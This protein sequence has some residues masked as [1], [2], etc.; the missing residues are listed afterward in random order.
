[1]RNAGGVTTRGIKDFVSA[2]GE[3]IFGVVEDDSGVFLCWEGEN[4][5]IKLF[6]SP[7]EY[8]EDILGAGD[9]AR[10]EGALLLPTGGVLGWGGGVPMSLLC[11]GGVRLE[12]GAR[13][14]LFGEGSRLDLDLC[15]TGPGLFDL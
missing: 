9:R 6:L 13:V 14:N 11:G 2:N 12:L 10:G 15:I 5:G 8:D 4:L 1:M 7:A 3:E